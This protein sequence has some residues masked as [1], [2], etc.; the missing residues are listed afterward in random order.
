M[1]VT[2]GWRKLHSQELHSLYLLHIIKMRESEMMDWVWP[3]ES[4]EWKRNACRSSVTHHRDCLFTQQ[5]S[6]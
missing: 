3:V 2:R 4:R 6:L 1:D 5:A